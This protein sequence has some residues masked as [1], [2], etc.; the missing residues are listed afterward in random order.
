MKKIR[1]IVQANHVVVSKW[2]TRLI[3]LG[4]AV[5]VAVISYV[6]FMGGA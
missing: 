2:E 6:I 5:I 4:I 3:I 1:T